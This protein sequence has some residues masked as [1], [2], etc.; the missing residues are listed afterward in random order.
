MAVFFFIFF[1]SSSSSTEDAHYYA[2]ITYG[3]FIIIHPLG[4]H[5]VRLLVLRCYSSLIV[6][7]A[8]LFARYRICFHHVGRHFSNILSTPQSTNE[9]NKAE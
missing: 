7:Q 9:E 2:P 1:T 8:D 6:L 4:T 3:E 5:G